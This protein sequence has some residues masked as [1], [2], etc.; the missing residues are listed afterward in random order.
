[1]KEKLK[2]FLRFAQAYRFYGIYLFAKIHWFGSSSVKLR[3]YGTIY[4]RK[5]TYDAEVFD[6][7]FISRQ[8]NFDI[9]EEVKVIVDLGGNN[10]MS[11]L[12]FHKKYPH[13][14]IYVLEPDKDNFAALKKQTAGIDNIISF[15]KAIW[16][17]DGTVSL[18][19]GDSWAIKIDLQ[20]GKNLVESITMN[21]LMSSC[22]IANIDLLKIDI[23]GAE[24]E[25][26]ENDTS[27]LSSTRIMVI[28]LHDWMK[29]GCAKSFFRALNNYDYDYAGIHE[30]ALITNLRLATGK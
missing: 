23:E 1:V 30:N 24:K 25:L 7:V 16:K 12:F 8:Y 15:N 29:K 11:A 20:S 19:S 21:T 5:K 2:K 6:Q 14:I 9:K 4:L 18:D 10:G 22:Q 28:E 27:F 13:A 3:K 26:F 17:E